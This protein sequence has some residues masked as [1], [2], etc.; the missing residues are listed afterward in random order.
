[1][2]TLSALAL[3]AAALFS[4]ISAPAE[5]APVVPPCAT[6]G[7]SFQCDGGRAL[8]HPSVEI[9][10]KDFNLSYVTTRVDGVEP[11]VTE[12]MVVLRDA[13]FPNMYHV[14]N[15]RFAPTLYV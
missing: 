5:S 7:A 1:M 6:M 12:Q 3:A 11:V 15:R 9:W 14:F 8:S 2:N 10:E 13:E 4:P